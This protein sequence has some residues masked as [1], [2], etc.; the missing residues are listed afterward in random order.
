MSEKEFSYEQLNS[1][2]NIL[3]SFEIEL[4]NSYDK[5]EFPLKV[6]HFLSFLKNNE[7]ISNFVNP[8]LK[9]DY[10]LTLEKWL[11]ENKNKDG[12]VGRNSVKLPENEEEK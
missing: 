10:K 9:K 8:I 7:I 1:A 3:K 2:L 5:D 4:K 12:L 11:E 6:R